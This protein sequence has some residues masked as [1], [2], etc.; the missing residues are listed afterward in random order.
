M[1]SERAM[2]ETAFSPRLVNS[3]TSS[4][5]DTRPAF[6]SSGRAVSRSFRTR[7]Q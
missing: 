5:W 6:C 1:A 3:F 2:S 4:S 7:T